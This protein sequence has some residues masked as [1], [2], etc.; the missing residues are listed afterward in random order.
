VGPRAD[1]VGQV[2]ADRYHVTRKLGEGGMGEVYLAEHVK[3]GR[4][5]ALKVI[6]PALVHEPDALARFTR[7]AANASRITHPNVA[8]IYDFG[9]TPDGV[10]FLAMEYVDGESLQNLLRREGSLPPDRVVAIVRQVAAALADAHALGI[11]HRDLK[12]EN[13]VVGRARDGGDLVKVVDFGIAKAVTGDRQQV[14]RTGFVLGTPDYM[15]PEQLAGE[16][17]DGQSDQY[18]LALVAFQMLTGKLPFAGRTEHEAMLKRLTAQPQKLAEA[19]PDVV[20]PQGLQEVFDRALSRRPQDRFPSVTDFAEALARALGFVTPAAGH[21]TAG[22]RGG[23]RA[24]SGAIVG[25]VI[26]LVAASAAMVTIT[27]RLVAR[28]SPAAMAAESARVDQPSGSRPTGPA[29]SA[30]ASA[31]KAEGGTR[32]SSALAPKTPPADSGSPD[33]A[34]RIVIVL[35]DSTAGESERPRGR[36]FFIPELSRPTGNPALDSAMAAVRRGLQVVDSIAKLDPETFRELR[37]L[38]PGGPPR[39]GGAVPPPTSDAEVR[40]RQRSADLALEGIENLID[41][42][43]SGY[44]PE[45]ELLRARQ[46]LERIEREP[47]GPEARVRARA[48]GLM[49]Q[50]LIT[51]S[52]VDC[53]ALRGVEVAGRRNRDL[54]RRVRAVVAKACGT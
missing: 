30:G 35:P 7:E 19:R 40:E 41:A 54:L 45:P 25:A 14:T 51:K 43:V 16:P 2:I 1:L 39:T 32:V 26:G 27:W 10:V 46:A 13:I 18:A 3:M 53:D 48:D 29:A 44:V 28:H 24:T 34:R 17:L 49:L 5:C 11:V 33:S 12:P 20:W 50:A 37:R 21:E 22:R 15:S 31:A 47:L 6:R 8:A 36:G 52:S 42:A 38:T 23:R 9:E 4:P